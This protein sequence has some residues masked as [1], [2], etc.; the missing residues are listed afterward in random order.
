MRKTK[1]QM[2][3]A[4]EVVRLQ[5]ERMASM[6]IPVEENAGG[7]TSHARGGAAHKVYFMMRRL[8]ANDFEQL[9]AEAN[10]AEGDELWLWLASRFEQREVNR[11]VGQQ[12]RR[13]ERRRWRGRRREARRQ[14]VEDML[15]LRC[16]WVVF[17]NPP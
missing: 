2:Q 7:D 15:S 11:Q 3:Q 13:Q 4:V 10:I 5:K 1:S 9:H 14:V 8:R 12:G 16:C 6:H 17:V